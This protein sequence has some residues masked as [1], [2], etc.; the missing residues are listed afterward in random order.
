MISRYRLASQNSKLFLNSSTI[1]LG[2]F[3]E[4]FDDYLI[5]GNSDLEPHDK[6][7]GHFLNSNNRVNLVKKKHNTCF[8]ATISLTLL[9]LL[10]LQTGNTS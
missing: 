3:T 5:L 7:L 2:Y 10:S 6:R 1:A 9:L 8:K 4:T